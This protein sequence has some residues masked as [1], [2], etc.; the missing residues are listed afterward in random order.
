MKAT[1]DRLAARQPQLF[2]ATDLRIA[3]VDLQAMA[4]IVG[5][6][7]SVLALVGRGW[8]WKLGL[9]CAVVAG[10]AAALATERWQA[11][12]AAQAGPAS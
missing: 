9:I 3:A 10:V 4:E 7:E 6:A 1:F 2:S 5:A 12:R 8:P 11:R